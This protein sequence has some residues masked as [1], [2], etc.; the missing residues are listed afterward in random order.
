MAMPGDARASWA[1]Q[2]RLGK[3]LWEARNREKIH[4]RG[5]RS[6]R[7]YPPRLQDLIAGHG[8]VVPEVLHRQG[9]RAAPWTWRHLQVERGI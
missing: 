1:A 5:G 6:G 7:T 4:G 2:W 9:Q 8:E 3:R